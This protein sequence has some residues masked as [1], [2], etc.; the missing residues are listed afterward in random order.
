MPQRR[1]TSHRKAKG[2]SILNTIQNKAFGLDNQTDDF[3][4]TADSDTD[5]A[6]TPQK[7]SYICNEH[8][9]DLF[10]ILTSIYNV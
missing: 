3:D 5:P 9:V 1:E 7:V 4:E 2:R 6:W 10:K 8:S